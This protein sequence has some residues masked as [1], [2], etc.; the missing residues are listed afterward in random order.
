MTINHEK[1]L[2][3]IHIPK[4]AGSS[5][6]NEM[7][8]E[9]VLIDKTVEE[10]KEIYNKYWH[11]YIK[12]T[13]IRDP[14]DRFISAYKFARMHKNVY[15]SPEDK[16]HHHEICNSMDINEYVEFLFSNNSEIDRWTKPQSVILSNK[17]GNFEI[18]YFVKYE[19]LYEDLKK[20]GI[21][22]LNKINDSTIEN[23]N[24]ISLTKKSKIL[25]SHMYYYDYKNFHY[26][27]KCLFL[28]YQ[29]I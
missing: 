11:N 19:N 8:R 25:L 26:L 22:N 5:I 29:Y 7:G 24:L 6:I 21:N 12:F 23:N 3:F 1:K 13:V 16:H 14:I 4:N 20:I 2:I 9:N 10:Y 17:E 27:N 18:D 15:F 28:K